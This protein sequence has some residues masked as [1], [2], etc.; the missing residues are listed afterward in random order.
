MN[1]LACGTSGAEDQ[2]MLLTWL[3]IAAFAFVVFETNV[4]EARYEH[5]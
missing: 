1:H 3:I 4:M 2:D 5:R